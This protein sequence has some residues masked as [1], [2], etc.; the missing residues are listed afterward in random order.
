M[1]SMQPQP[2]QMKSIQGMLRAYYYMINL[3]RFLT[4]LGTLLIVSAQSIYIPVN[5]PYAESLVL[6]T[7]NAHPELLK[8][9]LHAIPPGQ[10]DYAIIA[11]NFPSKIGKKSSASDLAVVRSGVASVKFDD[12]GGF[13][14]LCLPISDKVGK[15]IGI[16]VMEIP[17][18]FAKD[19]GEALS[20]ATAIR[21]EM[22]SKITN[23]SAL[24]EET[25]APLKA[26]QM[27][28]IPPAVKGCFDHF[29]VDLKHNRLFATP[30]DAHVVLVYDLVTAELLT[31]IPWRHQATLDTLSRR[32]RPDLRN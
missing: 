23:N 28:P 3:C 11:N 9:G 24:F 14:D 12:R 6:A 4:F 17:R 25:G 18:T 26:L 27:I 32:Y 22:Q 5:A 30:E 2:Q 8:L 20:R 10:Q 13:F 31:E 29:G 19:S 1:R 21:D 15:P 7:K 16:T